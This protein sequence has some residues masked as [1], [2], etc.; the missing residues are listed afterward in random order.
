MLTSIFEMLS[1]TFLLRAFIAGI[2][3]ALCAALIGSSIVLRRQSMIGDGLS[4]VAFGSA[5][6]AV[7]LG[8][9][10]LEFSIPIVVLASIFDSIKT[11]KLMA[12]LPLQFCPPPLSPLEHF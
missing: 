4:H 3:I 9:S 7:V 1:Y 10:P 6:I 11:L 12:M 2:I 8:F 5:A